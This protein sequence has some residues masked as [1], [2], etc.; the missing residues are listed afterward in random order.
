MSHP[1]LQELKALL[2][3]VDDIGSAGS[4]L[5][6]DQTTHMPPGGAPA[7]GRQLATLSKLAH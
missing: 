1:K 3:E 4:V 7:R 2:L 6:W 5:S